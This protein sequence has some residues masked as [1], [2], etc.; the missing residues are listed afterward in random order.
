MQACSDVG[1]GQCVWLSQKNEIV[2]V[3]DTI[4]GADNGVF[5]EVSRYRKH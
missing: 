1:E 4:Y 3:V 2:V 5:V